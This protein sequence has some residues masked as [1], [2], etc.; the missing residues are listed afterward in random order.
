VLK[1][2]NSIKSDKKETKLEEADFG[3]DDGGENN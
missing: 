1:K 2:Y 3:V